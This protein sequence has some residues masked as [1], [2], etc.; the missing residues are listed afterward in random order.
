M[1]QLYNKLFPKLSLISDIKIFENSC[2]HIWV[3]FQNL[4]KE[5]KNYIFDD[6]LPDT[7]NYFKKFE[8]EKSPRKK[9]LY[10]NNIF[11][12]ICN[13]AELN[14][15]KIEG[16]DDEM[17]LLYYSLINSK[18]KRIYSSCK[19]TEL[20]LGDKETKIEGS[21][22]TKI[23]AICEKIKNASYNDFYNLTESDYI[24]SC[25]LANKGLLY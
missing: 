6:Y 20:F 24:Y 12:C 5:N 9:L 16:A 14:G 3:E 23:I 7:I 18:C 8:K 11:K 10:L 25:D 17:P 22:L 4:I 15:E 13:L 2:R 19:Y 21:Q 1:E